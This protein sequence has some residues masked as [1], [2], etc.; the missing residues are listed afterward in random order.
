MATRRQIRRLARNPHRALADLADFEHIPDDNPDLLPHRLYF[1]ENS[2]TEEVLKLNAD[3]SVYVE[4]Y[5]LLARLPLARSW[6]VPR[7]L[8]AG[9][10]GY[11]DGNT[12]PRWA[13]NLIVQ[14]N[15]TVTPM[16]FMYGF[17]WDRSVEESTRLLEYLF[18]LSPANEDSDHYTTAWLAGMITD[19]AFHPDTDRT[20]ATVKF[21]ESLLLECAQKGYSL[22]T[23]DARRLSAYERIDQFGSESLRALFPPPCGLK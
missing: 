5:E 18:L 16:C 19:A 7:I 11:C 22:D 3:R 13:Q 20:R 4:E 10:G 6:A 23:P 9:W 2:R 14:N 21:L 15:L 8:E 1:M 17:A 12:S